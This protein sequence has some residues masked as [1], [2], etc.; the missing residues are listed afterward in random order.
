MSTQNINKQSLFAEHLESPSLVP[1]DL[2]RRPHGIWSGV[3]RYPNV[4]SPQLDIT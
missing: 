3:S 4:T 2:D 1:N